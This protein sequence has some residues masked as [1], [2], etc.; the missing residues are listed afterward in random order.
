MI[1]I[2]LRVLEKACSFDG[3]LMPK[4][5]NVYVILQ[6]KMSNVLNFE[7]VLVSMFYIIVKSYF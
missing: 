1:K 4:Y 2:R 6:T 5:P 7:D 3:I